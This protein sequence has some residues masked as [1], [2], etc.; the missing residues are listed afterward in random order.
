MN[1]GNKLKSTTTASALV[2][3]IA[4]VALFA[5]GILLFHL[6]GLIF[7][8]GTHSQ[9]DPIETQISDQS[10]IVRF[11]RGGRGSI[12]SIADVEVLDGDFERYVMLGSLLASADKQRVQALLAESDQLTKRDVQN[13]VRRELIRRLTALDPEAAIERARQITDDPNANL[14][15]SA[16]QEWSLIDLDSVS[17]YVGKQSYEDKRFALRV[18]LETRDDLSAGARLEIGRQLGLED[19]ADHLL[20]ME[21]LAKYFSDSAPT[22]NKAMN[23]AWM[24]YRERD[25][26]VRLVQDWTDMEG[27]EV[28]NRLESLIQDWS[29]RTKVMRD[30]LVNVG[31]SDLRRAISFVTQLEFD[32]YEQVAI[33]VVEQLATLDGEAVLRE[34]DR[35]RNGEVRENLVRAV[36][37]AWSRQN[38]PGVMEKIEL[39][40]EDFRSLAISEI[41][42]NSHLAPIEVAKWLGNIEEGRLGVALEI[43]DDWSHFDFRGA[44]EWVQS[45]P[46]VDGIRTDLLHRV[47][48]NVDSTNANLAFETALKTP[49]GESQIGLEARVVDALTFRHDELARSFLPRVRKGATALAAYSEVGQVFVIRGKSREAFRLGFDLPESQRTEFY[50]H[51]IAETLTTYTHVDVIALIG[52]LPTVQSKSDVAAFLLSYEYNGKSLSES[53]PKLAEQLEE[54]RSSRSSENID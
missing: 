49:I 29:V 35:V 51:V 43:A 44:L 25:D 34:V 36:V 48:Y 30:V 26:L 45:A 10:E 3:V 11:G 16:I 14:L 33:G 23:F 7:G 13:M 9:P 12:Q 52:N 50:G 47:L 21:K 8:S 31:K 27:L 40:P 2:G 24:D 38:P 1:A 39:I 17:D 46:E 32:L 4:S 54:L 22:E 53:R 19:F 28:L 15:Q 20:Q 42:R 37:V 5:A 6:V 18:I 41:R